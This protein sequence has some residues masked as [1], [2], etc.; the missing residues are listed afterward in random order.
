M[1]RMFLALAA[2]F[3]IGTLP[4]LA[5][6]TSTLSGKLVDVATYVTK[7]HNMDAMQGA[8]KGETMHSDAKK[9]EAMKDEHMGPCPALGLVTA[10]GAIYLVV[11][12]M[13]S[14]AG[15]SLCK[16]MNSAVTLSGKLYSQGGMNVI[17]VK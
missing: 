1:Q 14:A 13:E 10:K 6:T 7:D 16:K 8:M 9:S 17:L 15:A 12:Q 4:A 2:A 5:Q 3:I 11:T